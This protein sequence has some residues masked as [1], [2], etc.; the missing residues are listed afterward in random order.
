MT[1][2]LL[3][4]GLAT[5]LAGAAAAAPRRA[6]AATPRP[7]HESI[8][9]IIAGGELARS[10]LSI[11]VVDV[12]SGRVL[13][14]HEPDLP[15][16]PASNMKVM[17]SATALA[18]LRPE[19]VFSTAV[20]GAARLD[21]GV[22]RGDL[23]IK[24]YGSPGLVGEQWWLMARELR[25]RGL[26]RVEG[27]L[28]G[29]DT[30]FD[31]KERPDGWPPAS[32]DAFYNAP[33]SALATDY[34][35]V[36]IVVRP[37]REGAAPEVFLTPFSSFFKVTNRATTR[38]S[39]SNLRVGR[40]FDGSWN[41]IVVEGQI[42]PRSAPSVSYRS[43]EQ[44]TLYALAAFRE[45]AA[46]EGI[47]ITGGSRRGVVPGGAVKL[48]EHQ[49]RPVSEL[50]NTMN[51]MSNNYM[52]EVLLKTLGAETA[53]PPGTTA[54]GADAVRAFLQDL[55]VDARSLAISDGSGLSHE[56][57]LTASSLTAVLLAMH[58]D[59]ESAP[60][61]M[62]SL[63][64]GGVDGTL[65]RRMV[66]VPAQR[67][68]RAKTGHLNGASSLSGYAFTHEG[69]ILAFSILVNTARDGDIW[70]VRRGIDRICSAMVSALVPAGQ[71][72]A[73]ARARPRRSGSGG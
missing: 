15:L 26:A 63:A 28:V 31:S 30:Y 65:D 66:G 37:G 61:F 29:D 32:E 38:G 9:S 16:K 60:E 13:F 55:G 4:L 21:D 7:L 52:A 62:A 25:A 70:Q 17:T 40:Q 53:G 54:K 44:P 11:Q 72:T 41:S 73:T 5:L 22:V 3:L 71:S 43:V 35:A 68:V 58:R 50:I 1:R 39:M 56:N 42:S 8:R 64:V 34:S 6:S 24:G 49:S 27:D 10:R 51:K 57:R 20:F 59:F 45:A 67:Q 14:E 47:T 33:I 36:T 12:E 23:Y 19:F 18:L 48:Y 2:R 69:K 46:K